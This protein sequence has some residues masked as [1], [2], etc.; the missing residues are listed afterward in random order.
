MFIGGSKE[1]LERQSSEEALQLVGLVVPFFMTLYGL[2]VVTGFL[3]SASYVGLPFF[4]C[5]MVTW[6]IFGIYQFIIPIRNRFQVIRHVVVY[7]VFSV[8]F[9]LFVSGFSTSFISLLTILYIAS[10]LYLDI[11]G[12]VYSAIVVGLTV[13]ADFL[14]HPPSQQT[15]VLTLVAFTSTIIVGAAA[16]ALNRI[17]E[18]DQK[19]VVQREN[20]QTNRTLTLVNNLAEAVI[21]INQEGIIQIYNCLL[22]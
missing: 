6:N 15:V 3:P 2:A 4:V 17:R 16:I 22:Y 12:A 14:M 5:L 7:H 10:Y 9:L 8:L 18:F 21:S 19:E 1:K 13:V 20:L 11:R